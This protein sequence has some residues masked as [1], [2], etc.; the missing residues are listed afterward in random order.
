MEE[1]ADSDPEGD[2]EVLAE[3]GDAVVLGVEIGIAVEAGAKIGA[4]PPSKVRS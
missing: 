3:G 1:G 4:R 2:I